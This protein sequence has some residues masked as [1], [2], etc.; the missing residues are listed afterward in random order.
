MPALSMIGTRVSHYRIL[1]RLGA[2]GMGV[3]YKAEDTRLGRAVALKFLP[4]GVVADPT[5]LERFRREARSAS[6]L[7]HPNIC[8]IYE[9]DERENHP[10]I[11]MECL[12]GETLKERLLRGPMKTP[13]L[14]ELAIQMAAALDAAHTEGILHRDIKPA[15]IFITERGQAKILDFGLAKLLT[16]KVTE[17]AAVTSS[18][19]PTAVEIS[20]LTAPGSTPGTVAYMSPEQARGE[21]L[22]IRSDMFSFG[23]VLYE[24][25]TGRTAFAGETTAVTFDAILNRAPVSPVRLNPAV[26]VKLEEIIYKLLDKDRA[27]RYQH[28]SDLEADLKR[29]R[30]DSSGDQVSVSAE[31]S[32]TVTLPSSPKSPEGS[33]VSAAR[34]RTKYLV[35][36]AI[37]VVALVAIIGTIFLKPASPTLTERDVIVLADFVNTTG[38]AAFDGTLKQVLAFHLEQSPF[39]NIF[40]EDRISE[41]LRF[42]ERPPDERITESVARDICRLEGL[43]AILNGSIAALGSRYLVI[44][45]AVNCATGESIAQAQEQAGSKEQVIGALD[46]AAS[47]LRKKLGESLASLEKF[48]APIERA[49][50]SSLEALG[51]FTEG[52]RLNSAGAFRKAIPFLQRSV[53]LD[54]NFALGYYLLGTAYENSGKRSLAIENLTK[55]YQLRDRPSELEK[56]SITAFYQFNVLEDLNTAA[57]TYELLVHTYPRNY[58]AH[59]L[60]GL[61]YGSMGRFEDA[62]AQHLEAMRLQPSSALVRARVSDAYM[63]LNRLDEAKSVIDKAIEEKVEY[64]VMH[65]NLYDIAFMK[66]DVRAMQKE[67]DL[68]K[69]NPDWAT[70]LLRRQVQF[71]ISS[72]RIGEA[73]KLAGL[74]RQ[75]ESSDRWSVLTAWQRALFNIPAASDFKPRPG[76]LEAVGLFGNPSQLTKQID[77]AKKAAPQDTLLNFVSI[78]VARAMQ[79]IRLG[80]GAKAIELLKIAKPYERGS[81]RVVY[82]RGLAYLQ[83]GSGPEAAAEFQKIISNRGAVRHQWSLYLLSHLGLARAYKSMGDLPKARRSY[84]DFLTLWKGADSDIPILIQA[85][86]EYATLN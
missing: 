81:L 83:T 9:I 75:V 10:F 20:H 23:A 31:V 60:L 63:S 77:D 21:E 6:A 55:A 30:R 46:K 29:F 44:L 80:N 79:E 24:M 3:V 76:N 42:M 1:E 40:P 69:A 33:A 35:L 28:A 57:D 61:V 19:L 18:E 27:L 45:D 51:P 41:A 49:T 64:F 36:A 5:A 66:G 32:S 67:I 85:N 73:R 4:D 56:L 37:A 53:E 14:V 62:L 22:D 59:L 52:R 26:P 68:A 13:E 34:R 74:P 72:G 54:P 71:A 8:T 17:T 7:N 39:L 65:I 47:T 2:G 43:H 50:T 15:N 86:R 84:Q 82:T 58:Q 38:E 48:D 16:E 11:V 25:V 70:E 12:K 78:P